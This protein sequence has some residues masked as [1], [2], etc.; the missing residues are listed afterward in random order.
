MYH[1]NA[2][3]YISQQY[4]RFKFFKKNTIM[5][6]TLF[7]KMFDFKSNHENIEFCGDMH[8]C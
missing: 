7:K 4:E 6:T 3:R 2:S 5:G 1:G 8:M